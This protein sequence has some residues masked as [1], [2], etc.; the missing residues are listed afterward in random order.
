MLAGS[1]GERRRCRRDRIPVS[2]VAYATTVEA[3]DLREF[4]DQAGPSGSL[5][6]TQ[7]GTPFS[8]VQNVGAADAFSTTATANRNARTK[9]NFAIGFTPLGIHASSGATSAAEMAKLTCPTSGN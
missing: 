5:S 2:T 3:G 1:T 6:S 8:K 9:T 4:C 7:T